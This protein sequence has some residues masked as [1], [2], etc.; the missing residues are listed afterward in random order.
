MRIQRLQPVSKL[1]NVIFSNDQ[2]EKGGQAKQSFILR[3]AFRN[4]L[5]EAVIKT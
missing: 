5:S 4:I 3:V 1:A 2:V